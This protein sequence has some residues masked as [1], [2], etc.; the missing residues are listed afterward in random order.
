MTKT[1]A[2]ATPDFATFAA[3]REMVIANATFQSFI[4]RW[5]CH[6]HMSTCV[7]ILDLSTFQSKQMCMC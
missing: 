1:T 7:S 6:V 2:A 4:F 3:A 5:V